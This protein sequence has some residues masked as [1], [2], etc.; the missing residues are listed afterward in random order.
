MKNSS[1]LTLAIDGKQPRRVL[2]LDGA[3]TWQTYADCMSPTVA[4]RVLHDHYFVNDTV[5]ASRTIRRELAFLLRK[6]GSR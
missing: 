3:S 6:E 4:K 2:Y 1:N 5:K